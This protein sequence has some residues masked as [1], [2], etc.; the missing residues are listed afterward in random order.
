MAPASGL[1][2]PMFKNAAA[3]E[4]KHLPTGATSSNAKSGDDTAGDGQGA[5][6]QHHQ[7]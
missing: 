6:N 3:C 4:Q 2:M 7:P 1:A 5:K